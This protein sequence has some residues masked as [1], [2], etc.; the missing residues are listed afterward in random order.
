MDCCLISIIVPVYNVEL[1]LEKCLSSIVKQTYKNIEIILVNDGSTDKSLE[2]AKKYKFMDQRISVYS[3]QNGGLASARNYGLLKSKGNYIIFIDSDDYISC[4]HVENLYN[5]LIKY[6]AD[7]AVSK[8]QMIDTTDKSVG[9]TY[10]DTGDSIVLT[11]LESLKYLLLQKKFDNSASAKIYKRRIC[12]IYQFPEGKIYEDFA[13][14]YKIFMEAETVAYIDSSDYFYVQRPLSI[15]NSEFNENKLDLLYFTREMTSNKGL[16]ELNLSEYAKVRAF[17]ALVSLWRSI[18]IE[19]EN[20]VLVWEEIIKYR[21]S[22]FRVTDSK[23]KL[24]IGAILSYFGRKFSYSILS[25]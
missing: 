25:K 10:K 6:D 24:K 22:T 15:I 14:M 2:V 4:H 8:I 5:T 3:K 21:K 18:P 13:T 20:N 23:L 1:Y 19:N 11:K 17:A 16:Q 12:E 7:I 9:V